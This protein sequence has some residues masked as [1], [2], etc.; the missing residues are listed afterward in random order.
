MKRE[1]ANRSEEASLIGGYVKL[2]HLSAKNT[3]EWVNLLFMV[4]KSFFFFSLFSKRDE[5]K[6]AEVIS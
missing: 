6:S 3:D 2:T 4:T 5:G 1:R